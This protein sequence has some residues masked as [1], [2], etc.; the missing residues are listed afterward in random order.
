MK[1]FNNPF[2]LNKKL[3]YILGGNGLIGTEVSI[4]LANLGAKIIIIDKK[5]NLLTKSYKN[6]KFK[7]FDILNISKLKSF[8][9][10][11]IKKH[12]VPNIFVNCSY[13]KTSDWDKN[14]FKDIKYKSYTRNMDA[15]LNSYVWSSKIICDEM[16]KNKV[17]GSIILLNSIYGLVG[18]SEEV[19]KGTKIKENMTYSIIKG[20]LVNFTRQ[21]ASHYGKHNIRINSI[22]S[23]GIMEKNQK[24]QNNKFKKNYMKK[25]ILQ[26]LGN[27]NDISGAVA[28]LAS[29]AS[30]YVTGTNLI[31]DGG[32]TAI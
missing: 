29:D 18:Q 15:H 16:K 14:N 5:T 30:A 6:I 25:T 31:V 2:K 32:W 12:G 4:L 10:K 13:P 8:F 7:K 22:C 26:R 23:G 9:K 27:P 28:Y 11:S 20:G 24:K 3:V 21:I 17:N 19:Y 1:N